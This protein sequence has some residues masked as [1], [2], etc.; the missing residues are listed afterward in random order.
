MSIEFNDASLTI[1]VTAKP[2]R[3]GDRHFPA[4]AELMIG[5]APSDVIMTR[6][7]TSENNGLISTGWDC[8]TLDIKKC[9]K[10]LIKLLTTDID[11]S[12]IDGTHIDFNSKDKEAHKKYWPPE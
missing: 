5:R 8:V 6:R 7:S 12:D 4:P 2:L 10:G 11:T 3:R 9:K 1:R